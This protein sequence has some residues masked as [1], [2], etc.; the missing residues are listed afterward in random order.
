MADLQII[1]MDAYWETASIGSSMFTLLERAG[2]SGIRAASSAFLRSGKAAKLSILIYH[3]VLS[4]PDPML[5]WEPDARAFERQMALL[6]N[7]FAILPLADAVKRLK[8]GRLPRGAACVTFDDGYADN[9]EIA[10]P[11]LQ[12]WGVPATF[13]ISTSFLGGGCMWNDSVIESVR[14]ASGPVLDLTSI[15]I[16]C[17][18]IET[19]AQRRHL[20]GRVLAAL[21]YLSPNDRLER[22]AQIV[23][24]AS[25]LLPDCLMMT[26]DQIR[27]LSN[28]GM[29]IGGHTVNHPILTTIDNDAAR[30]EI[31]QG[32]EELTSII[33]APVK[34]FAYPN[35]KP[36]KDYQS[37]HVE[38]VRSVGFDAAVSTSWG[39][40]NQAADV[41]QLPR[42]TPWDKKPG[43]F[44]VRLIQNNLM[45]KAIIV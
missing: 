37:R 17:H 24:I 26:P 2:L 11:I 43:R 42:F 28:A 44:M 13:F 25:A 30:A 5:E 8:D 29:E 22:V 10:L 15:G 4:R 9:A 39:A 34:I 40:A 14:T 7:H 19:Y 18:P 41:Y 32:K 35:G 16:G 23:K 1:G 33:R 20:V 21:K 45:H 38:I 12:R 36:G 27:A 3:R 31:A 6:A